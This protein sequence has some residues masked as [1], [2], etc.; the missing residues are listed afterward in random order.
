MNRQQL[1]L[2]IIFDKTAEWGEKDDALMDLAD[3]TDKFVEQ[4][5]VKFILDQEEDENLKTEA[6]ESLI[7][8]WIALNKFDLIEFTQLPNDYQKV[9]CELL[10]RQKPDWIPIFEEAVGK[11]LR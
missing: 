3:Y 4:G 5:L 2:N 11:K 1:L 8:I 7:S 6:T 10:K 9:V